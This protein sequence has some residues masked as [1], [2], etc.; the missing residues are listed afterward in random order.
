MDSAGP[1][2]ASF[3][4]TESSIQSLLDLKQITWARQRYVAAWL[5]IFL[6]DLVMTLPEERKYIWNNKWT[7]LKV[8]YLLNRYTALAHQIFSATM[9]FAA[10]SSSFC[11]RAWWFEVVGG[12]VVVYLCALIMSIR[13]I[14]IYD[15]NIFVIGLLGVMLAGEAAVFIYCATLL[16]AFQLPAFVAQVIGFHGCIAGSRKIQYEKIGGAVWS[17]PLTFDLVAL[18]LTVFRCFKI[19]QVTGGRRTPLVRKILSTGI[20]YFAVITASNLVNVVLYSLPSVSP[21]LQTFHTAASDAI[22]SIMCSR[23]V[24]SLFSPDSMSF[25]SERFMTSQSAKNRTDRGGVTSNKDGIELKPSPKL[26]SNASPFIKISD[27]EQ[28]RPFDESI[29]SDHQRT[30]NLVGG[31]KIERETVTLASEPVSNLDSPRFFLF[32]E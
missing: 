13:I 28:A 25:V 8:L 10:I 26:F 5:G 9:I 12:M 29:V 24:L 7:P 31:V 17:A 15:R 18:S 14:A 11:H 27:I 1:P 21:S 23:L 6:F 20:F 30:I 2:S 3:P 4:P 32:S 16:R 22:T 19:S